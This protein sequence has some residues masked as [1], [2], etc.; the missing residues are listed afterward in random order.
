MGGWIAFVTIAITCYYSVVVGWCIKYILVFSKGFFVNGVTA[1]PRELWTTFIGGYEPSLF[2]IISVLLGAFVVWK[3]V[4]KGIE[5]AN[6]FF[7]PLLFVLL[8]FLAFK[9]ITMNGGKAGVHYLLFR[10]D[11]ADFSNASLWIEAFTQSAWST[12]AGWGLWL[13][14]GVYAKK[15]DNMLQSS[16]IVGIGNSF[17]SILAGLVVIPT[18][19]AATLQNSAS[20]VEILKSSSQGLT[21][22]QMVRLFDVLPGGRFIGLLFFITLFLAALSSFISMIELCVRL[23]GDMN[24]AR[25]KALRFIT[26]VIIILGLPS[27]LNNSIFINQDWIWSV[28]LLFSGVFFAFVVYKKGADTLRKEELSFQRK[29]I[30]VWWSFCMKYCVPLFSIGLV[31][32]WIIA[33]RNWSKGVAWWNPLGLYTPGSVLCQLGVLLILL[34]MFNKKMSKL[35][36]NRKDS[37]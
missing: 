2:H 27:A 28:G 32:W 4:V 25:T 19:F 15:Q 29:W 16:L 17:A 34:L 36:K 21:F 6:K 12:G 30:G 24:I 22:I 3:G 8:A 18:I 9:A 35:F 31:V 1:A 37:Q 13:T 7:L 11:I 5:K 33:S 26:P 23:L 20:R 10:F 14:Y